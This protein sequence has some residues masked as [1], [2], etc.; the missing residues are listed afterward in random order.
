MNL[1]PVPHLLYIHMI[2]LGETSIVS[3]SGPDIQ[4]EQKERQTWNI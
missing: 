3:A 1:I 2:I 4:Y